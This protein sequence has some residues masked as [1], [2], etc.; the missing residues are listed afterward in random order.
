MFVPYV[1]QRLPMHPGMGIA[2]YVAGTLEDQTGALSALEG[3]AA[4]ETSLI[5]VPKL[6]G[7]RAVKQFWS[8]GSTTPQLL[9]LRLYSFL[10][11][12]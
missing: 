2:T 12:M 9:N 1:L 11:S 4:L 10:V 3:A 6:E 5:A 8:Y 7:A